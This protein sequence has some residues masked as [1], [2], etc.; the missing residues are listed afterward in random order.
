MEGVGECCV[1]VLVAHV[2]AIHVHLH[3]HIQVGA[4][5]A[6]VLHAATAAAAG[7]AAVRRLREAGRRADIAAVWRPRGV[8]PT[9]QAQ[10]L[11]LVRV[12]R[13]TRA[14]CLLLLVGVH[15]QQGGVVRR[16]DVLHE[17]GV[18]IIHVVHPLPIIRGAKPVGQEGQ[19]AVRVVVVVTT[20]RVAAH[21]RGHTVAR[22]CS[23]L[24]TRP[25]LPAWGPGLGTLPLAARLLLHGS[26][27]GSSSSAVGVAVAVLRIHHKVL[28]QPRLLH[29]P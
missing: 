13:H 5:H 27:G 19:G 2:N 12:L 9:S 21:E 7:A 14:A 10:L 22:L 1:I 23:P 24:A 28:H 4:I 18:H 6:A 11:L 20:Q 29:P 26:G 25:P 8:G 15:G 3:R 17:Q 16:Q